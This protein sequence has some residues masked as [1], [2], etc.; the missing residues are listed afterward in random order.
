MIKDALGLIVIFAWFA[1]IF[2]VM[3]VI[4]SPVIKLAAFLIDSGGIL[5]LVGASILFIVLP[6]GGIWLLSTIYK[7]T[8]RIIP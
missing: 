1:F 3:A 4:V 2:I 8:L 6:F 7:V 5:A